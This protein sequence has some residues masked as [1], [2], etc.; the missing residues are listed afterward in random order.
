ME[1]SPL[2]TVFWTITQASINLKGFKSQTMF[3]TTIGLNSKLIKE[4]Q[5]E[6]V[7]YLEAK[8]HTSK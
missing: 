7:L 1:H 6:I 2:Q 3:S 4:K 5:I 8:K